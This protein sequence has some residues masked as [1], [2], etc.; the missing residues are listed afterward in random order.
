M[1]NLDNK[2]LQQFFWQLNRLAP[3]SVQAWEAASRHF[4][5]ESHQAGDSVITAGQQYRRLNFVLSGVARLYYVDMD[6]RAHDRAFFSDGQVLASMCSL[7]AAEVSPFSIQALTAMQSISLAYDKLQ[8]LEENFP[9]WRLL[10]LRIL[11]EMSMQLERREAEMLLK[12]AEQRYEKFL[13]E[14]TRHA[15][16]IPMQHIASVLGITEAALLRIQQ[17]HELNASREMLS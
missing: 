8:N 3:L 11:E 12:S 5:I 7:Q 14:F 16:H 2:S 6:G 4:R 15:E 13:K 1:S 9:Q 10:R 17:S